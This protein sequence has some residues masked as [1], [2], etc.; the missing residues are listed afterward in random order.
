MTMDRTPVRAVLSR[1]EQKSLSAALLLSQADIFKENG[2]APIMLLDDLASEFDDVHFSNVLDKT[3][4]IGGQ[5]WVTG[6]RKQEP[7]K[8]CSLFHVERGTVLKMV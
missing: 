2:I 7:D 3:E 8:D 4:Q 6:I 1:G 5:V